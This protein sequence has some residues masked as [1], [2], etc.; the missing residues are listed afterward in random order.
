MNN[1][2]KSEFEIIEFWSKITISLIDFV[3]KN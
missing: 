1:K 3:L 2:I